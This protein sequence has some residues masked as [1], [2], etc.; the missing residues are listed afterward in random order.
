MHE[1]SIVASP[2][3]VLAGAIMVTGGV[4]VLAFAPG[5]DGRTAGAIL[6]AGGG[7]ISL[8]GFVGWVLP[9]AELRDRR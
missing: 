7:L 2:I 8:T 6:A 4:L 3:V 5:S 1:A 9:L